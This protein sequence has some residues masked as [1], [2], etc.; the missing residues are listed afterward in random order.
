MTIP[1]I[2]VPSITPELSG[3]NTLAHKIK[4]QFDE[5]SFAPLKKLGYDFSNLAR[6]GKLKDDVTSEQIHGLTEAQIKL[7]KQRHYVGTPK[8]GLGFKLP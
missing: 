4:G 5:K 7:R 2:Q 6:L 8:F 3:S 1:V